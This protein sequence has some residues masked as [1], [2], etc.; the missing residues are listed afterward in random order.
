MRVAV[1][2][3]AESE[4]DELAYAYYAANEPGRVY[5]RRAYT[6]AYARRVYPLYRAHHV[7]RGIAMLLK[8]AGLTPNGGLA[9][10]VSRLA[11]HGMRFRAARLARAAA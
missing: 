6:R 11:W 9:R 4:D 7:E 8:A 1:A 3:V 2:R 5:D 10:A